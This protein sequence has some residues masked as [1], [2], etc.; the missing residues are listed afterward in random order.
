MGPSV[1][2]AR[3]RSSTA[4]RSSTR[5]LISTFLGNR[6]GLQRRADLL[7]RRRILDRRE[8]AG[9]APL[10][11]CLDRAAQELP[12]AGLRQQRH[13]AHPRPAPAPHELLVDGR[14]D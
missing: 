13:E 7:E 9:I 5:A 4:A 6:L 11:Y 10:A 14:P 3:A 12:G 1:A 8:V 2:K